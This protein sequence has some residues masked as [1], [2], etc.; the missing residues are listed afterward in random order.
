MIILDGLLSAFLG[1]D[2]FF[3]VE[4]IV[5]CGVILGLF[6]KTM[7]SLFLKIYQQAHEPTLL[8]ESCLSVVIVGKLSSPLH[9][10]FKF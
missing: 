5:N 2:I 3:L 10:A 8:C 6:N 4:F 9:I 1:Y 7:P